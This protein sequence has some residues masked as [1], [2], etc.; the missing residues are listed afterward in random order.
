MNDVWL[1]LSWVL[2]LMGAIIVFGSNAWLFYKARTGKYR[3]VK[4]E[5]VA[6][7]RIQVGP[8]DDELV[9]ADAD[10]MLRVMNIPRLLYTNYRD[11]VVGVAFT[12]AGVI[13]GSLVMFT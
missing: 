10:E 4:K 5:F 2:Q 1:I 9:K 13:L 6:Q 3:S 7:A 12:L 11:N 8:D